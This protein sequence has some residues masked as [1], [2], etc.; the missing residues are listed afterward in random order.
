MSTQSEYDKNQK[1]LAADQKRLQNARTKE[2]KRIAAIATIKSLYIQIRLTKLNNINPALVE[3]KN[4][5]ATIAIR[6]RQWNLDYKARLAINNPLT[7]ND[8]NAL[9]TDPIWGSNETNRLLKLVKQYKDRIKK[10]NADI[11]SYNKKIKELTPITLGQTPVAP[12]KPTVLPAAPAVTAPS[13]TFSTDYKYN[14]PMVTSAYLRNGI[15]ADSIS[16]SSIFNSDTE[17]KIPG[18]SINYPVFLDARNAWKGINGGKGTIQMD[19]ELINRIAEQQGS[20][21]SI[22]FDRQ[23]YGFKFMY[24]PTSVNMAWDVSTAMSPTFIG[25]GQ[26]KFNPISAG[27][28]SSVVEF[29]LVLNRIADFGQIGE[30]GIIVGANPYP[31]TVPEEDLAQ[32]YEKGTMYDL[33]YLFKTL[34]G[35]NA[36]FTSPLNGITADRGW[37]RPTIVELHLGKSMRYRVRIAEFAV[38]HIFFNNNMVPTFST[39]KLTCARFNDSP[40][41]FNSAINRGSSLNNQPSGGKYD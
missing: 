24:N 10:A 37:L 14:A 13:F 41:Y 16:G 38:N 28:L 33:E 23:L 2:E 5:E 40:D 34:N 27:L 7:V 4:L 20:S 18:T 26:D 8:E 11:D 30:G 39:V 36:T 31:V 1:A 35:P 32:I 25:S 22:K 6:K 3:I 17:I 29:E 21:S 12:V 19:K 9:E 15:Q